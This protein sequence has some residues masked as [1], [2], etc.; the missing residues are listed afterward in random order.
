V[1]NAGWDRWT[2]VNAVAIGAH[3][4]G[5]AG[6]LAA[7]RDRVRD[8]A[9]VGTSSVVKTA[10]TGLALGVTAY[11]RVQGAEASK[12]GDVPPRR[13]RQRVRHP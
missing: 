2:P 10:L 6:L 13:C 8:Q 1:A 7:N 3:V 4:L 5:A 12:A 11:S 9:G